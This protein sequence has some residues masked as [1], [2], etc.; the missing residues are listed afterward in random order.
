MRCTQVAFERG[1]W[2]EKKGMTE[3]GREVNGAGINASFAV[4]QDVD[5]RAVDRALGW[6]VALGSPYTFFTT[7][8]SEY[9]SDIFGERG[10]LLGGVHG[11]IE[12][13]FRRYREHG[14]G[15]DEAFSRAAEC[16]T[17][18]ITQCISHR[19]IRAVYEELAGDDEARATF[20]RAYC[21]AYDPCYEILE[22]CYD[23]V[24]CGNEVV[25]L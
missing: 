20:E 24:A 16:L 19:G 5:G 14:A 12:C 3:K 18:P 2:D 10:V 4:A 8:E 22:E 23:D 13:L 11:L 9:K 7:L 1:L 15:D 6:S 17:G 25:A 21:C